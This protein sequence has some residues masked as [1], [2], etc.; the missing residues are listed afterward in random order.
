[1]ARAT[2]WGVCAV[3]VLLVG[4]HGCDREPRFVESTT[5]LATGVSETS[6]PMGRSEDEVEVLLPEDVPNVFTEMAS[7]M[8][9]VPVFAVGD[10]PEGAV[11]A[12]SWLSVIEEA[13]EHSTT[14][15][16][17]NPKIVGEG[18]EE[19]EGQLVLEYGGGWLVVVENFRGDLGDVVGDEVGKVAGQSA[20]LLEVNGGWLVQW[21]FEGRWYGVFGRDVETDAVVSLALDMALLQGD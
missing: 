11:L 6:S 19:P 5:S 21:S 16:V 1:M 20:Y 4:A 3:A 18:G 14:K 9:G 15:S 2:L 7:S 13:A 10:L 12:E 17:P 8:G